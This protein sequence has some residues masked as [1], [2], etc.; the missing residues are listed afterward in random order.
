VYLIGGKKLGEPSYIFNN[1]WMLDL[2]TL[3]WSL[4]FSA[5]QKINRSSSTSVDKVIPEARYFHTASNYR[6][7]AI[8]IFGGLGPARDVDEIAD[9]ASEG[10]LSDLAIFDLARQEWRIPTVPE[11][12]EGPPARY[13][14]V[15]TISRDRLVI[16]GGER[17]AGGIKSTPQHLLDLH[18]FDLLKERWIHKRPFGTAN[19]HIGYYRSVLVTAP[20]TPS[21]YPLNN[22]EEEDRLLDNA[23]TLFQQIP[24]KIN[25][26]PSS[27]TQSFRSRSG[28]VEN[29]KEH[30]EERRPSRGNLNIIPETESADSE[31][32]IYL[33]STRQ[34]T[35]RE[36]SRLFMKIHS[37]QN[38][39]FTVEDNSHLLPQRGGYLPLRFPYGGIIGDWLLYCGTIPSQKSIEVPGRP[40]SS[41]LKPAAIHIFALHLP[42]QRFKTIDV[43]NI[44]LTGS[45]NRGVVWPERN[46]FVIFGHVGMDM[47]IDYSM[48]RS[49]FNHI[50]IVDLEVFGIYTPPKVTSGMFAKELALGMMNETAFSDMD[51]YT[52]DGYLIHVNSRILAHRW[53]MFTEVLNT[54]IYGEPNAGE[55]ARRPSIASS[56]VLSNQ[57]PALPVT[58]RPRV[59]HLPLKRDHAEAFLE[60]IY[61]NALPSPIDIP[62]L[63]SLL[64]LSKRYSPG[65]ERLAALVTDVLHR[66]LNEGNA[67]QIIEA[68][69]FSGQ[70]ALQIQAMLIMRMAADLKLQAQRRRLEM[71][72]KEGQPALTNGD[73]IGS[74]VDGKAPGMAAGISMGSNGSI[75]SSDSPIISPLRMEG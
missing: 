27:P 39:S 49:N 72:Q 4:V 5:D 11:G 57:H 6:N 62:T 9:G 17:R 15:A 21:T 26:E 23:E 30:S 2:S 63:C 14:H 29:A 44:F 70:T 40:P 43:G 3:V 8:I 67:W 55:Q 48:R 42:T 60:Y 35:T 61:T 58:E 71:R 24:A 10:C 19:D 73:E 22:R 65:L 59:L 41:P 64:V 36:I 31:P 32:Y 53:P 69:A 28:S 20:Y 1:V 18:V 46:A 7:E 54:C 34:R 68:A 25:S 66:Q 33:Y 50:V 74:P 45:W 38:D 52:K 47:N 37:P 12:M 51:V 75:Q 13:A 56:I 16:G